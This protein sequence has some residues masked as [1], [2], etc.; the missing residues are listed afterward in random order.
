MEVRTSPNIITVGEKSQGPASRGDIYI[1][2]TREQLF[3]C[4]RS[5]REQYA[6]EALIED[7][8]GGLQRK[9]YK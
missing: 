2:W 6:R 4:F 5:K 8:R 7:R 3:E 1:D 9:T